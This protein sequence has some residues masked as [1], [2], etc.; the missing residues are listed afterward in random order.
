M[1]TKIN[2]LSAIGAIL[3]VGWVGLSMAASPPERMNL[4]GVLRDNAGTPVDGTPAMTFQLFD[5]GAGC[6]GGGAL[7]LTDDHASVVVS[8]GLF[9]VALG[10]GTVTAGTASSLSEAFRDQAEVWVG[11]G[12]GGE[13]LCPRVRVLSAAYS[14]NADHLDGKT[15]TE[16]LDT[17]S[18]AQSKSGGLAVLGSVAVGTASPSANLEVRGSQ[19][20]SPAGPTV[21]LTA[22]G[23][24][25]NMTMGLRHSSGANA[26]IQSNGHLLLQPESGAVGIGTTNPSA[27][28]DVAGTANISGNLPVAGTVS[29]SQFVQQGFELKGTTSVTFLG[30]AGLGAMS[31]QCNTDFPGSRMCTT[32]EVSHTV[33]PPETTETGW[34]QPVVQIVSDGAG[35]GV[36][37]DVVSGFAADIDCSNWTLTAG[38]GSVVNEGTFPITGGSISVVSC[39]NAIIHVTCCGP[40]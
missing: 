14:L 13:S 15:S 3:L 25:S 5:T 11:I 6:P 34:V 36:R 19:P 37:V 32:L 40:P 33:N 4:Q 31:R 35:G 26:W 39:N 29:A 12:V 17:S 7:L 8:G 9:N 38:F 22:T 28:L 1:N 20:S 21:K 30:N 2:Q 24:G 27:T 10:G 16:F 18:S 23:T